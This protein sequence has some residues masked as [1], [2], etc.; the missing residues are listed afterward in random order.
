[1]YTVVPYLLSMV[2]YSRFFDF[3]KHGCRLCHDLRSSHRCRLILGSKVG[4]LGHV[5]EQ[6]GKRDVERY[7]QA[8]NTRS[9]A[10]PS[11][12]LVICHDIQY[13]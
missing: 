2:P 4:R 5:E 3:R 1:M 8:N 13:T 6:S 9:P 11:A 7:G 10:L 12:R